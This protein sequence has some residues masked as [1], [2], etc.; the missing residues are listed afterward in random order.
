M[1]LMLTVNVGQAV[2]IGDVAVIKLHA[3]D[4]AR[5]VLAFHTR[6]SPIRIITSGIVPEFFTTGIT[7]ERRRIEALR[8]AG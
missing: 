8:A 3:K 1:P 6:E 7:G 2:R 4:G 5:V